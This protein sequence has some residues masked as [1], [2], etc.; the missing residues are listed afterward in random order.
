MNVFHLRSFGTPIYPK[1]HAL[2]IYIVINSG[3]AIKCDFKSIV[4]NISMYLSTG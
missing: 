4:N 2:Y 3:Y 1:F